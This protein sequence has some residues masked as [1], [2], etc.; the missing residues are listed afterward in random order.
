MVLADLH[1]SKLSS[2]A[3]ASVHLPAKVFFCHRLP[4]ANMNGTYYMMLIIDFN[5]HD[6][7]R[8]VSWTE[9]EAHCQPYVSKGTYDYPADM[10]DESKTIA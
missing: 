4:L 5:I 2:R 9:C 6:Y 10:I 1:P 7:R 8:D 3:A